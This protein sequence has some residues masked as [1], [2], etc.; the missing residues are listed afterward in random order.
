MVSVSVS[1]C[2]A[3]H[4]SCDH[5]INNIILSASHFSLLFYAYRESTDSI[6]IFYLYS[7]FF[8]DCD[9]SLELSISF[10]TKSATGLLSSFELCHKPSG[11]R[12]RWWRSRPFQAYI[13][14]RLPTHQ[15]LIVTLNVIYLSKILNRIFL[16][17][18]H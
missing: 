2:R 7:N 1:S 15:L 6:L 13:C 12:V 10:W 5:L 4:A 3:R 11:R 18:S 17:S 16:R 9:Y 14:P 8:F